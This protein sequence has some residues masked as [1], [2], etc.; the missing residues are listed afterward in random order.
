[1]KFSIITPTY[2]RAYLLPNLIS[3]VLNQT[4]TDWELIIVDDGS[5][6]N[7]KEVVNSYHD[8]KIK[9]VYQSNA[10][11]SA[12]RNNGYEHSTGD[13]IVFV[14]SDDSLPNDFL[15]NLAKTIDDNNEKKA[16]YSTTR[17]YFDNN[18][19][20][21]KYTRQL[22]STDT[23]ESILKAGA[24]ICV[25][26]CVHRDCLIKHKFKSGI[27]PWED[28]HLFLRLIND[29]EIIETNAVI[30]QLIHDGSTVQIGLN[31]VKI[32]TVRNYA[33]IVMDLFN[34][35]ELF[36]HSKFKNL[37]NGYVFLKHQMFFY[38]ARINGQ[39][40]VARDILKDSTKFKFD[41]IYLLKSYLHLM[42]GNK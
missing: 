4:Y 38:Q 39:F 25:D 29:F 2:N 1:M 14:D 20:E 7:T 17:R 42:K 28:T 13:F 34:Y 40:D 33:R 11:R 9:Y 22:K 18:S 5:T 19:N 10:E 16:I 35:P 26:Q 36:P 37:I 12:A 8:P 3:C 6:D 41:I 31:D 24:V 21:Y 23:P 30:H 32:E 15:S 27:E